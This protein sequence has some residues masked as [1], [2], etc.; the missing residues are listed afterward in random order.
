M[1]FISHLILIPNFLCFLFL[2]VLQFGGSGFTVS[3]RI[4]RGACTVLFIFSYYLPGYD[5][6]F[7]LFKTVDSAAGQWIDM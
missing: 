1:I 3:Y 6:S 2:F 4:S 5:V 7:F